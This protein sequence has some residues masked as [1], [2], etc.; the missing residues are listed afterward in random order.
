MKQM[1]NNFVA[2]GYA[3]LSKA[4]FSAQQNEAIEADASRDRMDALNVNKSPFV[5]AELSQY[6]VAI[7]SGN[8]S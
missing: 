5:D 6:L 3:G 4:V 7:P 1:K 8:K 2:L